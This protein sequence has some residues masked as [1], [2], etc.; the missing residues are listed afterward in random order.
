MCSHWEAVAHPAR[1]V[2]CAGLDE[3][4]ATVI[5]DK[6]RANL[7]ALSSSLVTSTLM[8]NEVVDMEW[9]FGVTAASNEI[10]AVGGTYLQLKLVIDKGVGDGGGDAGDASKRTEDVRMELTL[11]QFYEFLA[12]MEQA[13]TYLDFLAS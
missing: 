11:P 5:C 6:W 9:T 1:C 8:V 10:E 13:K 4:R 3:A 2:A 12:S 7:S